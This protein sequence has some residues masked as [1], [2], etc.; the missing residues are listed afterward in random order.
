MCRINY[1]TNYTLTIML[2]KLKALHR[3]QH[4]RHTYRY[5][6]PIGGKRGTKCKHTCGIRNNVSF[7][8]ENQPT[9]CLWIFADYEMNSEYLVYNYIESASNQLHFNLHVHRAL[10]LIQITLPFSLLL[11]RLQSHLLLHSN[12]QLV[13]LFQFHF[14]FLNTVFQL[15]QDRK[16]GSLLNDSNQFIP[17]L[18]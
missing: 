15:Q 6:V 2:W 3:K 12:T 9:A 17:K 1:T 14:E 5:M 18:I 13:I 4:T 10:E 11:K 7:F 8:N 16:M